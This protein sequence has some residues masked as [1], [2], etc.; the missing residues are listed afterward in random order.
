[1]QYSDYQL[2]EFKRQF[3]TR[4]RRQYVAAVPMILIAIMIATTD[5]STGLAFGRFP[6]SVFVPVAI[7]A[8]LGIFI[9]S[10]RNWRCP[11]CDKYLG[12]GANPSFCPKCGVP[13]K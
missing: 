12:R 8:M 9:F 2:Q 5:R 10:L 7:V 4:R 1:M 6:A 13:L 3:A 11:A